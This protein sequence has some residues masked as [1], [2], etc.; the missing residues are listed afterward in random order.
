MTG[1]DLRA[2]RIA[3]RLTQQQVADALGVA[4]RTYQVYEQTEPPAW[5]T[6]EAATMMLRLHGAARSLRNER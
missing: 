3:E 2:A 5:L 1:A 4:L 6:T